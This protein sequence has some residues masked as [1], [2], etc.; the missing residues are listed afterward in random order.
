MPPHPSFYVRADL[1]SEVGLFDTSYRIA[2]DYDFMLRCLRRS[3][4]KVKYVPSVMVRMRAGGV[5]NA[6]LS[7]MLAKSREDLRAMRSQGTGG[8]PT[9]IAKNLRKLP[10]FFSAGSR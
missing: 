10:Q 1:L 9:L 6:S 2:A 8:W 3:S 5:S 4:V 7:S